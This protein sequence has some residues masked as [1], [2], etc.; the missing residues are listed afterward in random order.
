MDKLIITAAMVGAEVTEGDNPALP[1]SPEGSPAPPGSAGRRERPSCICMSASPTAR[2][3]RTRRPSG[4]PSGS[5]R[6]LRRDCPG[7]TGGAVGMTAEER[8]APLALSPE[9]A[10]LT[11]GSV[12]FGAGSSST[13]LTRLR[14]SPGECR[15]PG[16]TGGRGVRDGNNRDGRPPG[17][18]RVA[19]AAPPLR[20]GHGGARRHRRDPEEPP[21][22]GRGPAPRAPPGR[23][24][25]SAVR[26]C[27]SAR[28]RSSWAVMSGLVLKTTF[29]APRACR[30]KQRRTGRAG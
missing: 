24:R 13:S 23:L 14:P 16:Q 9:M 17:Q 7:S 18:E 6:H 22:H 29:V 8:G 11:T 1:V 4:G 27:P 3:P 20:P 28:W 5:S 19:S 15:N 25:A 30:R 21:R 2:R 10:T 12:N 26:N